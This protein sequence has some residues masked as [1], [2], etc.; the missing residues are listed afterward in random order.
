M[1]EP[2]VGIGEVMMERTRRLIAL[3]RALIE[4]G[5]PG[6]L[7]RAPADLAK[8]ETQL[9]GSAATSPAEGAILGDR[10]DASSAGSVFGKQ[11][12]PQ[13]SVIPGGRKGP[14]VDDPAHRQTM[15]TLFTVIQGGRRVD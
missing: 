6:V 8:L 1:G 2:E 4:I 12:L 3:D 7:E 11:A 10:L 13:V 14:A 9:F 15:R 5:E